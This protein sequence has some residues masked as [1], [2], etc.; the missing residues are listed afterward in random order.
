MS[1]IRSLVGPGIYKVGPWPYWTVP[2]TYTAFTYM[3]A[4]Y[5]CM[6]NHVVLYISTYDSFDSN[7]IHHMYYVCVCV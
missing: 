4:Q 3:H 2:S 1:N 7:I 6:H 5:P